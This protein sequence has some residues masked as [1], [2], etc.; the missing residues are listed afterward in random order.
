MAKRAISGPA[1]AV[2]FLAVGAAVILSTSYISDLFGSA[3]FQRR[4][5]SKLMISRPHQLGQKVLSLVDSAY[6]EAA[7]QSSTEVGKI[8]AGRAVWY[9]NS[10]QPPSV[11]QVKTSLCKRTHS[12]AEDLISSR[13]SSYNYSV[14]LPT[15]IYI[16]VTGPESFTLYTQGQ[17]IVGPGLN[18]IGS[19]SVNV[20]SR[21]WVIYNN[22]TEWVN[23]DMGNLFGNLCDRANKACQLRTCSCD[24]RVIEEGIDEIFETVGLSEYEI[25]N[26]ID[27]SIQEL[28]SKMDGNVT[29]TSRLN[30]IIDNDPD[31]TLETTLGCNC[32]INLPF[33]CFNSPPYIEDPTDTSQL[34]ECNAT[35]PCVRCNDDECR[36]ILPAYGCSAPFRMDVS[37]MGSEDLVYLAQHVGAH[38]VNASKLDVPVFK[39]NMLLSDQ[40]FKDFEIP[41]LFNFANARVAIVEN[42]TFNKLNPYPQKIF[43][44]KGF[45]TKY[46]EVANGAIGE[47][48]PNW[49][50]F[51][52]VD[53]RLLAAHY[54]DLGTYVLF[55]EVEFNCTG[56]IP[57]ALATVITEYPQNGTELLLGMSRKAYIYGTIECEDKKY[58]I[59]DK[60]LVFD[61][62]FWVSIDKDCPKP[63]ACNGTSANCQA[64]LTLP[65]P[66]T[67]GTC[68]NCFKHVDI[69]G[70]TIKRAEDN[71]IKCKHFSG[72]TTICEF[73]YDGQSVLGLLPSEDRIFAVPCTCYL[74]GEEA[75]CSSIVNLEYTESVKPEV[76]CPVAAPEGTFYSGFLGTKNCGSIHDRFDFDFTGQVCDVKC[77]ED[78][79]GA[80]RCG[81]CQID[82]ESQCGCGSCAFEVDPVQYNYQGEQKLYWLENNEI[83]YSNGT[84]AYSSEPSDDAQILSSTCTSV[85]PN[86]ICSGNLNLDNT[87]KSMFGGLFS[88]SRDI[89]YNTCLTPVTLVSRSIQIDICDCG[90]S[91]TDPELRTDSAR[92]RPDYFDKLSEDTGFLECCEVC[93]LAR[94]CAIEDDPK[95]EYQ[96]QSCKEILVETGGNKNDP[97]WPNFLSCCVEECVSS[98]TKC[99][100]MDS[101]KPFCEDPTCSLV[102]ENSCYPAVLDP[103][104]TTCLSLSCRDYDESYNFISK[105]FAFESDDL[106]AITCSPYLPAPG[107][108]SEG[109]CGVCTSRFLYEVTGK[110]SSYSQTTGFCELPSTPA[111]FETCYTQLK[112]YGKHSACLEVSCNYDSSEFVCGTK[113]SGTSCVT[114]LSGNI[115]GQCTESGICGANSTADGSYCL[116]VVHEDEIGLIS[117]WDY[118]INQLG[119]CCLDELCIERQNC[120]SS[121]GICDLDCQ[122]FDPDC[123][124]VSNVVRGCPNCNYCYGGFCTPNSG[125]I[126]GANCTVETQTVSGIEIGTCV[127]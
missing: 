70:V 124:V 107:C 92:F 79:T 72:S 31:Y 23:D 4:V 50:D 65:L 25:Q 43:N 125:Q 74:N 99:S 40:E 82:F 76:R 123:E 59:E 32:D 44:S 83:F 21:F 3:S 42:S 77:Y 57:Q 87:T 97:K 49:A 51:D 75:E 86:M 15:C 24:S 53:S 95:C 2:I 91:A 116:P 114:G 110:M 5:A 109:Q 90:K 78:M 64:A 10:P 112:N 111:L 55:P 46:F 88:N 30:V 45:S 29:C 73:Q 102:W 115:C 13:T 127:C 68:P 98:C 121:N 52:S 62:D 80:I 113:A 117:Y 47:L 58:L 105:N 104:H 26:A 37:T 93:S 119:C 35:T 89:Q 63:L 6:Q 96:G 16:N 61:L 71:S 118:D 67:P 9:C 103:T 41:T 34:N 28:T 1:A 94:A 12:I 60:N 81:D 101:N 66:R 108:G 36:S 126:C 48:Q 22:L 7:L 54:Y 33:G 18:S 120:P 56:L 20:T 14:Q 106:S 100:C 8:G 69:D 17:G 11:S 39:S 27:K 84:L 19:T 85:A 122:G 38:H